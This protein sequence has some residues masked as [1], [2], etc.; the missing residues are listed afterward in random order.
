MW[1]A[2]KVQN[3]SLN[4]L[5]A[6]PTLT[7]AWKPHVSTLSTFGTI[8]DCLMEFN[9]N[10]LRN[11]TTGYEGKQD[12]GP[13]KNGTA[14]SSGKQDS[15]VLRLWEECQQCAKG[16]KYCFYFLKLVWG[17]VRLLLDFRTRWVKKDSWDRWNTFHMLKRR[18]GDGKEEGRGM[19]RL[20]K[21][22]SKAEHTNNRAELWYTRV[23]KK[24][25]VENATYHYKVTQAQ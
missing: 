12:G 1:R 24:P 22:T 2:C 25:I 21:E 3:H 20:R 14:T 7:W 9:K 18:Q 17:K 19:E 11:H 13:A 8:S 10:F 5:F 16:C 15:M 23:R 4:L 6:D